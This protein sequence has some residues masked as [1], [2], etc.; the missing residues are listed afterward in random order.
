MVAGAS[1]VEL[2]GGSSFALDDSG[3]FE[4]AF[5]LGVVEVSREVG[6]SEC[7]VGGEENFVGP[8]GQVEGIFPCALYPLLVSH[9]GE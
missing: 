3:F 7:I 9:H 8:L 2:K 1:S 5:E 6:I 4:V